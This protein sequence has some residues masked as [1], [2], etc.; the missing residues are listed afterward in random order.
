MMIAPFRLRGYFLEY[1][2]TTFLF[3]V[4]VLRSETTGSL[5]TQVPRGNLTPQQVQ[6]T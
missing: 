2:N 5:I 6:F 3:Q 4:S 1:G